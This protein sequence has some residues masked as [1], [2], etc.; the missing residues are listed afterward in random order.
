MYFKGLNLA[1]T[2]LTK[3]PIAIIRAL[4]LAMTGTVL[5]I[6]PTTASDEVAKPWRLNTCENKSTNGKISE[7][8]KLEP[9]A[10][11][12]IPNAVFTVPENT[13]PTLLCCNNKPIS[14]TRP[15]TIAGVL[16]MLIR[17]SS[18]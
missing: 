6:A 7:T 13:C 1:I 12:N 14:A 17:K 15:K 18:I 2:T 3:N 16:R 11:T 4:V 5:C 10:R 8:I 9:A